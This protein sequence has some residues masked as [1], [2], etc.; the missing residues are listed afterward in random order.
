[1]T[2]LT[3]IVAATRNNGIG[4]GGQLPWRLAKEMA[5]FKRVTTSAPEGSMNAVVMGRNT[6]ESIPQKFRP[7]NK[8]LNIVISSNKHYELLPPDTV[9]PCAPVYLHTNLD[10]TMERLSQPQFLECPIHRSFVIGGASLYRETLALPPTSQSFVDR[11]LLTRVLS[12]AFEECD[13]FMPDFIADGEREGKPWRQASHEELQEWAGFE[14]A[15]G[16]QEEN[17]VQYEFQMWVR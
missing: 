2:R 17:G 6:W 1:M 3:L 14:V 13:V 5:Y 12:P 10:S 11:V 15:A 16:T 4:Q 8:R 7:L 9:T